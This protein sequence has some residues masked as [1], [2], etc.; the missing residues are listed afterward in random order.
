M[1]NDISA[2]KNLIS[3][4]LSVL[5]KFTSITQ[6]F[7]FIPV[8]YFFPR[9]IIWVTVKKW[10]WIEKK[11]NLSNKCQN[12]KGSKI[13]QSRQWR[14]LWAYLGRIQGSGWSWQRVPGAERT[15]RPGPATAPAPDRAP[16]RR[17]GPRTQAPLES[18]I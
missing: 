11:K 9:T 1:T 10:I 16:P 12:L 15:C 13:Q 8:V 5:Q 3:S 14:W 6:K 7:D 4:I 2:Y 18:P 17:I